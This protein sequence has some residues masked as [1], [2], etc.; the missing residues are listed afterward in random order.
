MIH[1]D[2]YRISI[3]LYGRDDILRRPSDPHQ[4]QTERKSCNYRFHVNRYTA[5]HTMAAASER[6]KGNES[7]GD[8]FD[9]RF[10]KIASTWTRRMQG[11][12]RLRGKGR[13]AEK[14]RRGGKGVKIDP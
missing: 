1:Q 11:G 4:A 10:S 5:Y 9:G 6:T 3:F 13:R 8:R 12:G 14:M 7:S 2:L